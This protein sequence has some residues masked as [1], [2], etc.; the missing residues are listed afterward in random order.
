[1]YMYV[2]V[3]QM[4]AELLSMSWFLLVNQTEKKY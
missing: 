3:T 1:M 4:N 2:I